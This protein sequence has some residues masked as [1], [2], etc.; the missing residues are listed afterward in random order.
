[1]AEL[2]SNEGEVSKRKLSFTIIPPCSNELPSDGFLQNEERQPLLATAL[3]H[4]NSFHFSPL[5]PL[6]CT[7]FLNERTSRLIGRLIVYLDHA[8]VN[9]ISSYVY[10]NRRINTMLGYDTRMFIIET[11]TLYPCWPYILNV[12]SSH[13]YFY[14]SKSRISPIVL[15]KILLYINNLHYVRSTWNKTMNFSVNVNYIHF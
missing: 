2:I 6:L 12:Y 15:F 7:R 1:M 3:L 9:V 8:S 13:L 11:I 5:P 14:V 4:A 10:F